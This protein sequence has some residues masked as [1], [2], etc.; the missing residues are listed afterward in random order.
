MTRGYA[1]APGG[2]G[3]VQMEA[4]IRHHATFPVS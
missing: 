1:V 2:K 3:R 4:H